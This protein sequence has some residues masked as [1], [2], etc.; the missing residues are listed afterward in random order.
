MYKNLVEQNNFETGDML[1]FH[2]HDNCS[3]CG[4]CLFSCFTDCIMC[5]TKSIYSH[6]AIIIRD[7]P[8][9][10]SLKGLYIIESSYEP[11]GDSE[12]NEIKLGCLMVPFEKMIEDFDGDVYWRHIECER[13]NNFYQ[14]LA[15]AHSVVH[16]RPY[17]LDPVDWIKA[18]FK[19][20]SGN[21]QRKDTFFCSAMVAFFY[22][23]LGL[24]DSNTEWTIMSCENLGTEYPQDELK[25]KNCSISKEIKI[26]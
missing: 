25:F 14:K 22:T 8:W 18:K 10:Q 17:D 9:D 3:S 21:D 15:E 5:C 2:H 23:Q 12:N 19:I 16:N 24:L 13:D 4:N 20:H 7:P 6:S 26:K 1:L 11:Y